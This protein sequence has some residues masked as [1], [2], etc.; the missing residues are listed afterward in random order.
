MPR[1]DCLDAD[2]ALRLLGPEPLPWWLRLPSD[3]AAVWAALRGGATGQETR[4]RRGG[5]RGQ[6][7]EQGLDCFWPPRRRRPEQLVNPN[8]M[9]ECRNGLVETGRSHPLT[10]LEAF[11][12]RE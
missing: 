5:G 8:D 3:S 7:R 4:A 9:H 10:L 1:T 2:D 12:R 11:G 6:S